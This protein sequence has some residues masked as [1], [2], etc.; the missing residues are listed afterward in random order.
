MSVS[1][2]NEEAALESDMEEELEGETEETAPTWVLEKPLNA[3]ETNSYISS[4]FEF[5]HASL[6]NSIIIKLLD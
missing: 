1:L 4:I 3:D 5:E 6:K 2:R